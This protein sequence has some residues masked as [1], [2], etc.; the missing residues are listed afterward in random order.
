MGVVYEA[1]D[2]ARNA[3]V[4]LKTVRQKDA[5]AIYR[6]K[7]EFRA[8]AD[9]SHPNLIPLY[10]LSVTGDEWFLTMPLIDG[11]D[12]LCYVR[13]EPGRRLDES[14]PRGE[15]LATTGQRPNH[16]ANGR[17]RGRSTGS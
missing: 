13:P 4:A 10:E 2:R 1:I 7:Q 11:V 9:L 12:F 5:A 17:L 3:R 14:E 6:F 8:L 16:P 15:G